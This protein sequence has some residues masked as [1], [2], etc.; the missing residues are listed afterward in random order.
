MLYRILA[1]LALFFF[2][3]CGGAKEI[4]E[5]EH[6]P[7]NTEAAE[8]LHHPFPVPGEAQ[9]S[10]AEVAP[11]P[12]TVATKVVKIGLLLPLSG[13]AANVGTALLDSATLALMDKYGYTEADGL[14]LKAVLVPKDTKGTAEGAADAA[15]DVI[16]SGAQ[17]IVG[18]LF[19]KEVTAVSPIARKANI[20]VITFSNN[21]DVAGN[22]VFVFGFMVDQQVTRVVN[23]ALNNN[24][25]SIGLLAPSSPYGMSVKKAAENLL[26]SSGL[27]L[28]AD[29]EYSPTSSAAAEVDKLVAKNTTSKLQA[30]LLPEGGDK[31]ASIARNLKQRGIASPNVRLL[32]TGL[33]DEAGVTKAEALTGGW[34]ASSSPER[35]VA[36]DHRFRDYFGYAP[37]RVSALAYDAMALASSLAM[38]SADANFSIDAITDTVGYNGPVNGIFRCHSNGIC[39]RGL[40]VLEI[41]PQG[42]RIIDPA[43]KAFDVP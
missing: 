20:N 22:G 38:A 7:A 14:H 33:W 2:T 41:S 1:L 16:A 8:T 30:V 3:A 6:K 31:L 12:P 34:F 28:A 4:G 24:L 17:L 19:A 36:F 27:S 15:K 13:E 18:P 43:P 42:S 37:P 9:I 32:G 5:A 40:A 35:F 26:Q 21:P 29:I 39:E 10:P 25:S 11:A 23:Y